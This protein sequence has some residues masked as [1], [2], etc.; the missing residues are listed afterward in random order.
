[1][2]LRSFVAILHFWSESPGTLSDSSD[3]T[4]PL[5]QQAGQISSLNLHLGGNKKSGNS[6]DQ[7][8]FC[9]V[10]VIANPFS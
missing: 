2:G 7:G 3:Y 4:G 9:H 6:I 8:S 5:C 10:K 1:M